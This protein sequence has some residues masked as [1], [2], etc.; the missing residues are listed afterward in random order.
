MSKLKQDVFDK[1]HAKAV[2]SIARKRPPPQRSFKDLEII[3]ITS[4][5]T[6]V[7]L[8]RMHKD[9][10]N[11][12]VRY[13]AALVPEK[14]C[15]PNPS[16]GIPATL[17]SE[18]LDGVPIAIPYDKQTLYFFIIEVMVDADEV[19]QF[20]MRLD[21]MYCC[22]FR[23]IKRTE[24]P[25]KKVWYSFGKVSILPLRLFNNREKSGLS[26][27]YNSF[28]KIQIY[29]GVIAKFCNHFRHFRP[30]RNDPVAQV[31]KDTVYFIFS[32]A[33]RFWFAMGLSFK[34]IQ[35]EQKYAVRLTELMGD[36]IQ[37]YGNSSRLGVYLWLAFLE[38]NMALSAKCL[39][40]D[41]TRFPDLLLAFGEEAKTFFKFEQLLNFK[42][43]NND[44]SLEALVGESLFIVKY[45][46]VLV[47]KALMRKAGYNRIF[48][49]MTPISP[50][51]D[52]NCYDDD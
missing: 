8:L 10:H 7:H 18:I 19:F 2:A 29:K 4:T 44:L 16:G 45:S 31:L 6:A 43:P 51:D 24:D 50:D 47:R 49:V 34:G 17:K 35:N 32:E 1:A 22:G 27:A 26:L 42:G 33:S 5:P 20:P 14:V 3:R 46:C 37:S 52:V 13:N 36:L 11:L 48:P 9:I 21:S 28:E 12:F 39:L 15:F 23:C 40:H 38:R 30:C 25:L 41:P